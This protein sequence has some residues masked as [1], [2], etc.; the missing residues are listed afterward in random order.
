MTKPVLEQDLSKP[1]ARND[2]RAVF[3]QSPSQ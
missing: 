2:R 1:D 3:Y